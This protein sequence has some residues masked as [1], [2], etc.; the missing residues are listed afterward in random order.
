[1]EVAGEIEPAAI[2]LDLTLP[3]MD[4]WEILRRLRQHP[5]LGATP[6]VLVTGVGGEENPVRGFQMGADD[7]VTKPFSVVDLRARVRR[8]IL[9]RRGGGQPTPGM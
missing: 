2:I 9:R 8:Q 6:V 7:F 5:T 4:G 3:G 1:M